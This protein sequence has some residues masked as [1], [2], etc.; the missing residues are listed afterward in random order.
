MSKDTRI[1]FKEKEIASVDKEISS[2]D[3]TPPHKKE[4][5]YNKWFNKEWKTCWP[6][7]IYNHIIELLHKC[8]IT[9]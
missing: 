2:S 9:D 3:L 1:M 8:S 4:K 5:P 7:G 6:I